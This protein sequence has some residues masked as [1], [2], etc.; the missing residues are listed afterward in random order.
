M[1]SYIMQHSGIRLC[2]NLRGRTT[3]IPTR[4]MEPLVRS[5]LR[6]I[7]VYLK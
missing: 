2:F 7:E 6:D 5:S 4:A 3:D 1:S